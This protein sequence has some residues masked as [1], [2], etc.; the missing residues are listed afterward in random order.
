MDI[1]TNANGEIVLLNDG[2]II[3]LPTTPAVT[4]IPVVVNYQSAVSSPATL[5]DGQNDE[6]TVTFSIAQGKN[7]VNIQSGYA[8]IKG[9]NPNGLVGTGYF[10]AEP[11][12]AGGVLIDNW[13]PSANSGGG[14]ARFKVNSAGT[15][16]IVF[17]CIIEGTRITLADGSTK[18]IEN[19]TYE[20][21]LLVW[22][23]YT[24]GFDKAKPTWIKTA[25]VAP[26]Y[27]LVK[28]SNG[29][30]IGFVGAG[31]NV[32]YHRIFNKEAGAFTH[33]GTSDTP[34]GTTTFAEDGTFPTVISQEVV[35]KEVKF[36]NIITD[37]HYNLFAN[38]ILT[39]CRLSN[40]YAIDD[41][42]YIGKLKISEAEEKAY[43]SNIIL[44]KKA[45][46][47]N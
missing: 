37:K 18:A 1:I 14:A 5:Y 15:I 22:N 43:F 2:S 25:E 6:S 12:V 28:F 10:A 46:D 9:D 32:G 29:A 42:K 44:N 27:N 23:F 3:G 17:A 34:N 8:Y 38:K 36:Y 7:N 20:D 40:K 24:G 31:G 41:M 11:I 21:E 26:K 19:I 30:E 4:S 47:N 39:S 45:I 13:D 16:D 35:E 33:T